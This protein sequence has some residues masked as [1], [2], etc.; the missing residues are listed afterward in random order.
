MAE[1]RFPKA[2]VNDVRLD[3]M[4]EYVTFPNTGIGSR[5]SGMPKGNQMSHT[6]SHLSLEHVGGTATG[7]R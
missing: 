1:G 2:Y 6:D 7:S 3:P 5:T 4:M